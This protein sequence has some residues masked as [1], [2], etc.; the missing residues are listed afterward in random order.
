MSKSEGCEPSVTFP[1]KPPGPPKV[2]KIVEIK[3][4][5]ADVPIRFTIQEVPEDRYEEVVEHMCKYFIADEPMCK[6]I[7][8]I[9][10]PE[11]V[12]TFRCLWNELIKCG[13]SIVAFTENPDGGKP[14]IAG[15]NI[16]TLSFK[17]EKFDT[18]KIKS[19]KGNAVMSVVIE[20]S[21]QANVFEK[22]GVNKYMNAFGLSVN[23]KY[24]G[25][26]LGAHLLNARV[27][28]GREYDIPVTVTAFTSPI[29][30]K[31]AERC[32]FE[33]LVERNYDEIVDEKGNL[34]FPGIEAKAMKVMGRRLF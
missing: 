31:L 21:K 29:S 15:A 6:C 4:K 20:L 26:S 9:N 3:K 25:A 13:L 5:N 19:E 12:E 34:V 7:N 10:D 30:Q 18:E 23:P 1:I 17:D 11:Y 2:W 32:G 8:G 27:E 22:Y 28:I 24:R 16:L 14:I 33:T